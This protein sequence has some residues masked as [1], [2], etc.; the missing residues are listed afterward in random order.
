MSFRSV[1]ECEEMV[2]KQYSSLGWDY[3]DTDFNDVGC[4]KMQ[5]KYK[6]YTCFI[7]STIQTGLFQF[8]GFKLNSAFFFFF[9]FFL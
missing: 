7:H 2:K 4:G 8:K 6:I 1:A 3:S 9:F 5:V